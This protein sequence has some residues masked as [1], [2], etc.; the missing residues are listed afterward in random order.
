MDADLNDISI[1]LEGFGADAPLQ[2]ER[3]E[4][5]LS[6]LPKKEK[7]NLL[8]SESPELMPMIDDFLEK[9]D[10]LQTLFIPLLD[11]KI[12]KN[13]SAVGVKYVQ[14]RAQL[15]LQYCL[16]CTFYFYLKSAGRLVKGHPCL[17]QI[18]QVRALFDKLEKL[19][20]RLLPQL[21]GAA[22]GSMVA[23]ELE[24]E[25]EEEQ[26]E[27]EQEEEE[28]AG[29]EGGSDV[30]GLSDL[31]DLPQEFDGE[32]DDDVEDGEEDEEDG[33][34]DDE[35]EEEEEF[36]MTRKGKGK[37]VAGGKKGKEA[38]KATKSKGGKIALGAAELG[39]AEADQALDFYNSFKQ[40]KQSKK[41]TPAAAKAAVREISPILDDDDDKLSGTS[42]R[43]ATNQIVN[44]KGLVPYRKKENR[45]PRKKLR[46]KYEKAVKRR[47]V[48]KYS[49]KQ[50]N[51]GGEAAGIRTNLVRSVK[52]S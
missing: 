44:N 5:D 40:Q 21:Q 2:L 24:E 10:E 6:N 14:M 16:L 35:D 41:Q 51:Y 23:G 27:Q 26:E 50:E 29:E 31:D 18:V 8:M 19:H 4:R 48:K 9:L 47:Q 42:R 28:A 7:L 45:N 33:V 1:G 32:D 13:L 43:K 38:Q 20:Q 22:D 49:G 12:T 39:S 36:V 3:I 52:L 30:E 37:E 25:E 11:S 46:N 17:T 15:L 34:D